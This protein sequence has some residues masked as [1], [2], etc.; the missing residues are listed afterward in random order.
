M[1]NTINTKKAWLDETAAF[2]AEDLQKLTDVSL[3]REL[4][5]KE[6]SMVSLFGAYLYLYRTA[7]L[8]HLL[9]KLTDSEQEIFTNETIH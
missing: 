9:N 1:D 6:A 8:Q 3:T 4:T 5:E 2:V 7:N